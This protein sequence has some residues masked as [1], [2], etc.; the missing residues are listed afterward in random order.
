M[1]GWPGTLIWFLS[2][3][4]FHVVVEGPFFAEGALAQLAFKLP[5]G[6]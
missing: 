2:T 6:E 1:A 4:Q 3:V 5:A